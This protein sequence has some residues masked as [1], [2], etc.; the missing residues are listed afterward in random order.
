MHTLPWISLFLLL[1]ASGN[2]LWVCTIP[3][4]TIG[5]RFY[6]MGA[7]I[8][9]FLGLCALM[10]TGIVSIPLAVYAGGCF[11]LSVL[12]AIL[13]PMP[14]RGLCAIAGAAGLGIAL[15]A[16]RESW[17]AVA[18]A[19]PTAVLLGGT[20]QT[21]LLGHSYLN[22][23]NLPFGLLV[24]SSVR[25]LVTTGARAAVSAVGTALAWSAFATWWDRDPVLVL[26]LIVRF[27]VGLVGVFTLTWMALVCAKIQSNQSAT[28]ILYVVVAFAIMGEAMACYLGVHKGAWL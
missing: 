15:V 5:Q 28:G 13:P 24:D 11:V 4:Q 23:A 16:L 6:R 3:I 7:Y 17:P 14:V 9:L 19:V 18:M 10:S 2:L 27:L 12:A 21:M 1:F 22:M 26:F 25:L 8:S 20:L